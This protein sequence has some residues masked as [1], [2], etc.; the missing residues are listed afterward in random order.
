MKGE[1]IGKGRFAEVNAWGDNQVL[2]L[3]YENHSLAS[4]ENEA[5]VSRIAYHS[6]FRAITP[7]VGELIEADGRHGIIFQRI[8]GISMLTDMSAGPWL[9][10]RSARLLAEQ[11]AFM[12]DNIGR[13]KMT[14]E[15]S[16]GK[17]P[18]TLTAYEKN[19]EYSHIE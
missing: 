12:H 16:G 5:R 8:D 17:G 3:F 14:W 13:E 9:L 11:H 4:A 1:L 10:I 2:K 18:Q 7:A 19:N 6:D 15:L